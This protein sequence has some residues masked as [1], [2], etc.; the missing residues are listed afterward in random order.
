MSGQHLLL[1][2]PDGKDETLQR[3]L[4]GHADSAPHRPPGEQRHDRGRHGH[5]RGRTVLGHRARGHV[6]VKDL[7]DR[8]GLDAELLG[9]RAHVGQR[10]L[11]RLLH[12]VPE[13][14]GQRQ[15]SAVS[16]GR[17]R[18]GCLDEQHIAA[19]S[20]HGEAGRHARH[21]GAGRDLVV[22]RR[23]AEELT[24]PIGRDLDGHSQR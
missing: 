19:D 18:R 14:T 7:L 8:R 13:L 2:A 12:H 5:A 3:D 20:G 15:A 16:V 23:L 21:R 17:R 24:H 10:D 6:D 9:V 11:R 22:E 1:D 4:A